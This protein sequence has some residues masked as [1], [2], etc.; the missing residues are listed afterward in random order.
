[1]INLLIFLALVNNMSK[2]L[3]ITYTDYPPVV[4]GKITE[5]CWYHASVI[6]DFVQLM[7]KKGSQPT[8][9]TKVYLL[10]DNENLYF[11]IN[12]LDAPNQIKASTKIRDSDRISWDDGI[13]IFISP[14]KN[15]MEG[16]VF[17][18]NVLG[19]QRDLKLSE[20]GNSIFPE[21]DGDWS[22][23]VVVTENGWEAEISIP[24]RILKYNEKENVW[25]FN[26]IRGIIRK[27]EIISWCNVSSQFRI[28]DFGYISGFDFK[29]RNR[30]KKRINFKFSPYGSLFW[31][32]ERE[33]PKFGIESFRINFTT[34]IKS[35]FTLYP[36]YAHIEADID[37]FNLDKLPQWLPEK[38]PFFMEGMTTFDTPI[39]LLYTRSIGDIIGGTKVLGKPAG[40]DIGFLATINDTTQKEKT[41]AGRLK[42]TFGNCNI[43]IFGLY[44]LEPENKVL[45]AD[46]SAILIKQIYLSGQIAKSW[47]AN[48][49]SDLLYYIRARREVDTGVNFQ[50]LHK[51][52]PSNFIDIRGYIPMCDLINTEAN[53]TPK[54]QINRW[55]IRNFSFS[56]SYTNWQTTANSPIKKGG[57]GGIGFSFV[58]NF[59]GTCYFNEEQRWYENRCYKNLIWTITGSYLQGGMTGINL[60]YAWGNYWGGKLYYPSINLNYTFFRQLTSSFIVNYQVIEYADKPSDKAL[61]AVLIS[62]F[63]LTRNLNLRSFLQWSNKSEI[64]MTNFLLDWNITDRSKL[65]IALN[66]KSTLDSTENEQKWEFFI[67]IRS[68]IWF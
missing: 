66:R 46:G 40:F 47:L 19:T 32:D 36:D 48:R 50:I 15:G 38:R 60:Y 43:G 7:P 3:D 49:G 23:E 39:T 10:Y 37:E 1:M 8:E 29:I 13:V 20:G 63:N 68:S 64:L 34:E 35:E 5:E 53:L 51:Y 54:F 6:T 27:M 33:N 31:R 67:K 41:V 28:A 2:S 45:D 30:G 14:G 18:L 65:Y 22:G 24:F 61:I 21:W 55:L 16:Y 11:G 58:K 25:K 57:G 12:C 4:D 56:G 59:S 44:D 9:S 52:I 62:S 42:K 17:Q 26:F